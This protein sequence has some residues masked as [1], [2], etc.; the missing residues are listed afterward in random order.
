MRRSSLVVLFVFA[1]GSIF[2]QTASSPASPRLLEDENIPRLIGHS[3]TSNGAMEF[4][5]ILTDTIGGRITG[6]PGSRRAA[7][8][9][10][11]TLKAA[12]FETARAEG[13]ELPSVWR[14]GSTTCEVISPVRRALVIGSYG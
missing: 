12:G 14:H 13:Y 2:A 4:L 5:E 1:V 10:L 3:F 11:R 9:I 8:L 6:S 7:E